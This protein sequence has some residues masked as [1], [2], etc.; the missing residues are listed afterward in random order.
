MRCQNLN[1]ATILDIGA[2]KGI[3]SYWMHKTI[4][5]HGNVIAFE[6][7]PEL[8]QYLNDIKSAFRL[9]RLTIV[10]AG[11]SSSAGSRQLMR[12]R[13]HW[14]GAS[15][16]HIKNTGKIDSIMISVTTLC[17]YFAQHEYLRPI[18]FVK[19]DIEGHEHECFIGGEQILYEDHPDLLFECGD[20]RIEKVRSYLSSLGYQGY[21]FH[22]GRLRTIDELN[23]YRH[24]I[25]EP[26]LNYV[27]R[28]I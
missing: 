18:R 9:K 3:Y 19:C 4:G 13:D 25:H 20:R 17:D 2:N 27:F 8:C 7:Q 15:L 16:E 26:Y 6:P 11:L 28:V 5:T 12:P 1:G 24:T 14:G 23:E 21:Y 10:S 22:N